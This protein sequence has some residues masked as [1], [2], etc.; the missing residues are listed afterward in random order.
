M[1]KSAVS[2]ATSILWTSPIAF[3]RHIF[4]KDKPITD[5]GIAIAIEAEITYSPVTLPFNPCTIKIEDA[6]EAKV[7]SGATLAPTLAQPKAI[8]CKDPPKMSPSCK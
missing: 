6:T 1:P 8:I 4:V 7:T 3:V 2:L 5:R